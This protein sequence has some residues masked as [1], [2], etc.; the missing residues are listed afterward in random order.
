MS[1]RL[2]HRNPLVLD[3]HELDRRAGTMK[4]VHKEVPAP[5]DLGIQMIGVPEGSDI[6]LDL[7]L[8]AVVEGVLV[9]GTAAV[10]LQGQCTRCLEPITYN[11]TFE[12]QEL[13]YYPGRDAEEEA[14]FVVD[15][16]IDLDPALRDAIVL[17]L[18]FAPL[19]RQDCLGLCPE[20]GAQL[21]ADPDH[22][23]GDQVDPRWA[24]LTALQVSDGDNT[25]K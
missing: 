18:P 11:D 19:C 15:D 1:Q 7:R 17:E 20:C 10:E 13:Y 21:N 3:V 25:S 6:D 2:D 8:E 16:L 4:R 14:L 24:D 23:H 9:S 12:L 5:V 22:S